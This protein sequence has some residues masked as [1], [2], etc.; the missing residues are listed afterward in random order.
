M[1]NLSLDKQG[2]LN[3][4]HECSRNTV[5]QYMEAQ[6][7]L[8]IW[9]EMNP[10]IH[11]F[12]WR[13]MNL[14]PIFVRL[15]FFLI[16]DRLCQSISNTDILPSYKSDHSTPNIFLAFMDMSHGPGYWKLNTSLLDDQVFVTELDKIFEIELAQSYQDKC[17]HWEVIKLA[18]RNYV[19]QY[20][21]KKKKETENKLAALQRKLKTIE[22][23]LHHQTIFQ[24]SLQEIALIKNEIND[25]MVHKTN[26]VILR[27]KA[28]WVAAGEKPTS[29][30]LCMEQRQQNAR[31]V[32]VIQKDDGSVI[33]FRS[34][35]LKEMNKFYEILYRT[36]KEELQTPC[37]YLH[38]LTIPSLTEME[39][40]SLDD[41]IVTEEIIEAIKALKPNKCP[42]L[43]GL[44][45]NFYKKV[46]GRLPPFPSYILK[47]YWKRRC[48][49]QHGEG[50]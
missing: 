49:C 33:T 14:S 2:G 45:A 48:I 26:G 3:L 30:F 42:G 36:R 23:S 40:W 28:N 25:I 7:L 32:D 29:Y 15:D 27:C 35:I 12:T 4:T 13:R 20:A 22:H 6:E 38:D 31:V 21:A 50:L 46:C 5:K 43:D 41:P 44:P 1:L 18:V 34:D 8:D 24:D 17:K 37:N 16:T 9:R 19:L 47:F 11:R 39:K 10:D